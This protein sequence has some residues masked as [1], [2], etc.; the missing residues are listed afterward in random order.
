MMGGEP[1]KEMGPS[2]AEDLLGKM[3]ADLGMPAMPKE[4]PTTTALDTDV[5]KIKQQRESIEKD[6]KNAQEKENEAMTFLE[7]LIQGGAGLQ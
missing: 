6:M 1:G 5:D 4:G 3:M 2:N 7:K